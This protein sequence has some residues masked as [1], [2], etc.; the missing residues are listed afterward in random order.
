MKGLLKMIFNQCNFFFGWCRR[1][2]VTLDLKI[3]VPTNKSK[4]TIAKMEIT[5]TNEQKVKVT[6]NPVTAAGKPAELDGEP[7]WSVSSGSC[8]LDVAEDGMSAYVIS[9][10]DAGPSVI[11]IDAD[12]DLGEGIENIQAHLDVTVVG[13][14]ASQL[15]ATVGTPELK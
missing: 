14:R 11:L 7:M 4:T 15:G 1:K 13:A 12:A 9:G 10:D 3:G 6:L 2:R 8:T 5:I